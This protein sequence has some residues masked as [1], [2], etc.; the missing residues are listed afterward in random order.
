MPAFISYLP[1]FFSRDALLY[2]RLFFFNFQVGD[3]LVATDCVNYDMDC[4]NFTLPWDPNYRHALGELPFTGGLK[5]KIYTSLH[6]I[7]M[8]VADD[9]PLFEVGS[10]QL[11][12]AVTCLN[13]S[14]FT[15]FSFP[16]T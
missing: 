11:L 4:R 13:T 5:V 1:L 9:E 7:E 10:C 16:L 12:C 8:L 14:S 2:R 6:M 3:L 15:P